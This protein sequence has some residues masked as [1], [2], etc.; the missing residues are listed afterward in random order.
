VHFDLKPDNLLVRVRV[1]GVTHPYSPVPPLCHVSPIGTAC[2]PLTPPLAPQVSIAP[3]GVL[4]IKVCDLGESRH[5]RS[6]C[7]GQTAGDAFATSAYYRAPDVAITAKA[8]VY[9][10]AVVIA[11][12][13]LQHV[14]VGAPL[15][16]PCECC[17]LGRASLSTFAT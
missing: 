6:F 12:M 1:V 4:T 7:R 14:E 5:S 13:A 2:P 15:A 10:T 16:P 8:D 17:N 9:S 3:D 11:E